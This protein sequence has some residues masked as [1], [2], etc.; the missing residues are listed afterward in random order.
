MICG[1]K[2]TQGKQLNSSGLNGWCG[3]ERSEREGSIVWRED[4][5]ADKLT[6]E[7]RALEATDGLFEV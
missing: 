2:K 7:P 6:K 1:V 3:F 4:G 5:A